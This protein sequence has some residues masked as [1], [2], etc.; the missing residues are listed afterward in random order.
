MAV[1]TQYRFLERGKIE[2][3]DVYLAY[4]RTD[5]GRY[6]VETLVNLWIQEKA[7]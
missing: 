1:L 5:G 3:E 2:G 7:A 6:A 4:E